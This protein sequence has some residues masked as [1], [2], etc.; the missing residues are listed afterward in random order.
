MRSRLLA[1]PVLCAGLAVGAAGAVA[2]SH[3][4][5][6]ALALLG[7]A[8]LAAELLED[9]ETKRGREPAGPGVVR[10]ASGVDLAAVIVLGPWRGALVAGAAALTARVARGAWRPAAFQASAFALGAF[11][12]GYAFRFGGGHVGR[13]ALPDDVVPLTVLAL[14][15]LV[16]SRGLLELVGSG[17]TP[18]LDLAT[19]AAEA[20]LGTVHALFAVH[21]RT[22]AV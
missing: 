11:A 14:A 15:Y 1:Y 13:L 4:P 17:E 10:V 9:P 18:V 5:L 19:G 6:T 16:A 22:G 7:A 12:G 20:G 8:A 2:A 3:R 21:A